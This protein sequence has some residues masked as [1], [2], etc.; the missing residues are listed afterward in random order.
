MLV[1]GKWFDGSTSYLEGH[2]R[3]QTLAG[4]A[5]W[6]PTF[7]PR[8]FPQRS[9]IRHLLYTL[10]CHRICCFMTGTFVMFTAGVSHSFVSAALFFVMTDTPLLNLIFQ[11]GPNPPQQFLVNGLEFVVEGAEPDLDVY[12]YTITREHFRMLF[13]FFDIE[14]SAPC[15]RPSNF[16]F[17]HFI[18]EHSERLFREICY[19]PVS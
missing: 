18:W 15:G 12:Y 10:H 8:P 4:N 7:V 16:N 3:L 1:D 14:T 13:S 19:T 17:V 5:S 6:V 11:K 9:V 2:R